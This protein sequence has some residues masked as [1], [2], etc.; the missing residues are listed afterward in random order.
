MTIYSAGLRVCEVVNLRKADMLTDRGPLFIRSSKGKKDRYTLLSE[1]L[2][3]LLEEYLKEYKP[4]YWL[5]EG[6]DHGQYSVRSVQQIWRDAVQVSSVNPYATVHAL[7]HSFAT[8]LLENGTDLRYIQE[9]LGHINPKTN[10][11]YTLSRN[12][13]W[14]RFE[15]RWIFYR[16]A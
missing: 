11:I 5:F 6:Q 2:K 7:R 13:G 8:H 3:P 4:S 9:L 12:G 16:T 10:Q 15:V 14:I 1:K